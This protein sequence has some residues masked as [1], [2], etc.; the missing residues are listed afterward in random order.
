LALYFKNY[1]RVAGNG[2]YIDGF[3]GTG[4]IK[5]AGEERPGSA[6][7]A[8][9]SSAFKDLLFFELPRKAKRLQRHIASHVPE[10]KARRCSVFA[11]DFNRNIEPILELEGIDRSKPCFAFLDP[12]STQ[13]EW[14]TVERLAQYKGGP[15]AGLKIELWIL[16][17]TH[18]ALFRLM[19][20]K[21]GASYASSPEARTLD[22]VLGGRDAWWDLFVERQKPVAL[23][24]RYANRLKSLGYGASRLHL[25]LD[26]ESKRPQYYMIPIHASD[27]KAAFSF[28]RWAEIQTSQER[29]ETPQL[30][31]TEV[32]LG[33]G[34]IV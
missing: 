8:I 11:G 32:P 9:S 1:R 5:V 21:P 20:L 19:P 33:G 17:N 18:Q 6:S 24:H 12:D 2:T 4:L 26:R 29:Y 31:S 22:R 23:A 15:G 10:Q 25:I 34:P 28:M 13:L 3:A 7:I 27:H 14:A 30:F 16:L